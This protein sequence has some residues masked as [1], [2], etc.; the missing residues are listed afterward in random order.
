MVVLILFWSTEI[1]IQIIQGI[2][3]SS[4]EPTREGVKGHRIMDSFI[5]NKDLSVSMLFGK[6]PSMRD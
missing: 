3:L 2:S 6:C 1:T 4:E 5:M